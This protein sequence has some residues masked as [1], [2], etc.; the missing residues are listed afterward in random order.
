MF[1]N[2]LDIENLPNPNPNPSNF[3]TLRKFSNIFWLWKFS[4]FGTSTFEILFLI[5]FFDDHSIRVLLM[6]HSTTA[7]ADSVDHFFHS[8]FY[9]CHF[10]SYFPLFSICFL[11]STFEI[12][13]PIFFFNDHSI[14]WV[15]Q[16]ILLLLLTRGS[17]WTLRKF[18][19]IC[20]LWKFVDFWT[21]SLLL[22][23]DYGSLNTFILLLLLTR[24]SLW[25]LKNF[26][27]FWFSIIDF[28]FSIFWFSI[29]DFRFFF[30]MLHVRRGPY[31]VCPIWQEVLPLS[32]SLVL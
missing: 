16:Y 29:F 5:F 10:Q 11:T 22:I 27:D 8:I 15:I 3:Q 32:M 9:L 30:S 20:W 26:F 6:D 2:F 31:G 28:R 14:L 19:N 7:A 24:W 13:F 25:T 18:S 1:E 12:L 4:D 23:I 17:I 21:S